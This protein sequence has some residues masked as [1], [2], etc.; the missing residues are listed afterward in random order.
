MIF[1]PTFS[2]HERSV[3]GRLQLLGL[4]GERTVNPRQEFRAGLREQLVA[5]AGRE[6]RT[7]C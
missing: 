2:K 3:V 4:D 1:A 5:A 6:I 7:A